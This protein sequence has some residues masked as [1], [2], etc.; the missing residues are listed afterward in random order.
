[1]PTEADYKDQIKISVQFR[2]HYESQGAF[3][4]AQW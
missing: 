2:D 1:M 4:M 3:Q